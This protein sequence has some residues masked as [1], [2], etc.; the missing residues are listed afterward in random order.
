M[1]LKLTPEVM[2]ESI[3]FF[4]FS[5]MFFFSDSFSLLLF[6][7]AFLLLLT[8]PLAFSSISLLI[9]SSLYS[10]NCPVTLAAFSRLQ[11]ISYLSFDIVTSL[12]ESPL[13]ASLNLKLFDLFSNTFSPSFSL[14]FPKFNILSL[15][16]LLSLSLLTLLLLFFSS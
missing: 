8:N 9:L 13:L 10:D 7:E 6:N 14:L 5:T 4:S 1:F 15:E 16:P 2:F 11:A 12:L 3:F